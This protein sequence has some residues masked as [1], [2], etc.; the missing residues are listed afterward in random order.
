M[1]LEPLRVFEESCYDITPSS[2][3]ITLWSSAS[4][5]FIEQH[6]GVCMCMCVCVCVENLMPTFCA[7]NFLMWP[8]MLL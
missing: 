8:F 4:G 2:Q 3:I 6:C 1:G 5:S 7:L